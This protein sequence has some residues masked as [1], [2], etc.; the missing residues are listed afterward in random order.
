MRRK[1]LNKLN[2]KTANNE[3]KKIEILFA[4]HWAVLEENIFD[5]SYFSVCYAL[6]RIF[7]LK[8]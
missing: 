2:I 7:R 8:Y 6:K 5:F 4:A 3:K 1:F